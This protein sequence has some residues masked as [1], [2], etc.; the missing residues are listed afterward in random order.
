SPSEGL[1]LAERGYQILTNWK[2]DHIKFG[3]HLEIN[4]GEFFNVHT[5]KKTIDTY[6][7]SVLYF[8]THRFQ[9]FMEGAVA[10]WNMGAGADFDAPVFRYAS[11]AMLNSWVNACALVTLDKQ[12]YYHVQPLLWMKD[13]LIINGRSY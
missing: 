2:S 13:K 12:G 8:H 7:K 1:K 3:K 9:I 4:H 5:A 6:R 10:G 11:R